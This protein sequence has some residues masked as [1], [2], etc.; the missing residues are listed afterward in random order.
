MGTPPFPGPNSD[1]EQRRTL[2]EFLDRA[3][4]AINSGDRASSDALAK[5]VLGVD[6]GNMDAEELLSAPA[7]GGQI[8][9]MTI[10]F[11]DLVDSTVLSMQVEPEIY[12]TVVG[13]YKAEVRDAVARYDGF[14]SST[15]GDGLLVVWGYPHAHEDDVHRAVQAGLEITHDVAR[16]SE[17]VAARFGFTIDVRVGIHRGLIYLDTDQ[18]DVYGAGANLAAR[19]CGLADPGGVVISEAVQQLVRD[20]FELVARE[21]QRVK[22]VS[23]PVNHYSV[24]A[25]R[26]L[27]AV[28][29]VV[30]IGRAEPLA[31]LEENWRKASAGTLESSGVVF[32]GEAGIGKSRL[33]WAAQDLAQRSGA[34]VLQLNGSPLHTGDGLHPVRRLL[35]RRLGITRH[36]DPSERLRQLEREI[37]Q[38]DLD[39][40]TVVPLLAPVL[41]IPP[42]SGYRA[43]PAEGGRLLD[44]I[45]EAVH[46][47]LVGCVTGRPTLLVVEDMHWFDEDTVAV[48]NSLLG[49][50]LPSTVIVMTGREASSLPDSSRAQLFELQPL[51]EQETDD[52]IVALKP[53][54]GADARQMVR[55]RS[56]GI[57]LYIEELVD[58]LDRQPVD[59]SRSIEVPDSL[60]EALFARLRSS[61]RAALVVEAA[62]FIGRNVDRSL[63]L[64]V[65]DPSVRDDF[66]QIMAD[67]VADRVFERIDDDKWRFRHEL[68]REVATELAPPS[69]QRNLH[70][71]VADALMAATA[72]GNPYWSAVATHYEHA[73][74][75]V[76]A[77]A[78]YQRASADAR[79]RGALEEAQTALTQAITQVEMAD[80][81]DERDRLEAA[82]R[83]S[84]GFLA[85]AAEG[86][87]SE[88]AVADFERCIQLCES[89]LHEDQA[90]ATFVSLYGY[91]SLRADL[92]RV[93]QLL[94]F[95]D[96]LRAQLEVRRQELFQP[97]N[98][99]ARGMLAWYRGEF[100]ESL[101]KLE[102]AAHTRSDEHSAEMDA[103]W[104]M[105]NEAT[106]SIYTHLALSRYIVGDLAGAE[107][108]LDRT[109][110]RCRTLAFPQGA[111]SMAYARQIE[112]L[113]RIEAGELERARDVALALG[114]DAEN[115]G[116][117]SWA[118]VAAA[119]HATVEAMTALANAE[120][121]SEV[122]QHH[123]D[124]LTMF[125]DGMWRA[126]EVKALI[127]FYDA[128]IARLL[129]ADGQFEAARQRVDIGLAL[130]EE[131]GMAFYDAE[132]LRI[133]AGTHDEDE[134]RLADLRAA[135]QLARDQ[136]AAIFGLRAAAELADPE[137]LVDAVDRMPPDGAWPELA[138]AH[139]RLRN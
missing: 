130:S 111:F 34:D 26:E 88:E 83:L 79:Q 112:V 113:I 18:E 81:G 110:E 107:V 24:V 91:Y 96:D 40:S 33:V 106:A 6:Q 76:D 127:T 47:Y 95:F 22:G 119:Q 125:V 109:E 67:L 90:I 80:A 23:E 51:T 114:I 68:L 5:R 43:A 77:A 3:V 133:R 9:R 46:D 121:D 35:E 52:L 4:V 50:Q 139:A 56:D 66:D 65:A 1:A 72:N 116:F 136:G 108:E 29:G 45:S 134:P 57:P 28:P 55:S 84:R 129:V 19:M 13:R 97:F 60:Y 32:L 11:A 92:D 10:M 15:K 37:G 122:L 49:E 69:R 53:D 36:T 132:L 135:V 59:A 118:V 2:D 117:D 100:A 16:L 82:L 27:E 104:S 105:P 123:I 38:R 48:V 17:R 8:R 70:G 103:V 73:D 74:R 85:S 31:W 115:C 94:D 102:S 71:R 101:S 21:P 44:L 120:T 137:A 99:A 7:D 62:A 126:L 86:L 128:V 78:C 20:R 58:K 54:L 87:G 63:L 98:D 61:D 39:T 41:G 138:E 30:L 64:A 131:T 75:H 14:I 12:R 93:R 89:D 42:E 25:E 124:T